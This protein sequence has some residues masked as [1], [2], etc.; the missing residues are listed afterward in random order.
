MP[1]GWTG[2]WARPPRPRNKKDLKNVGPSVQY[3]LRDKTG[4]AREFLNYMQPIDIDGDYVFLAG[5][6]DTPSEEFRYLRIPA[7][8]EDSLQEWMRLRGA[9]NNPDLRAKAAARYAQRTLPRP[10]EDG[11]H[12]QQQLEQSAAKSLSIF[13]GDG[14]EAGYLAVARFL[15]AVPAAEQERAADIF[16]KILNGSLWDLWQAARAQ[17]GLPALE[18]ERKARALPAAG[19]QRAVRRLVLRRAG[20]PAA[21]RLRGNQGLGACKSR[22][23]RA[24]PWSTSAASCWCWACFRCCTSASGACGYGSSRC[25]ARRRRKP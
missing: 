3:K 17:D 21:G 9:L 8:D 15:E 14:K 7:D 10:R 2:I 18:A 4:Q 13:A 20:L 5:I 16:M 11:E 6:R 19:R 22:V 25:R 23:R 24:R 1:K 12:L